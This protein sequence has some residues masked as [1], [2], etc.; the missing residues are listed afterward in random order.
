M[1][2]NI[3]DLPFGAQL[4][5]RTEKTLGA[6]LDRILTDSGLS[7]AEYVAM[8][9]CSELIGSQ[10]AEVEAQ[11]AAVFRRGDDHASALLDRLASAEVIDCDALRPLQLTATGLALR[12]RIA[13]E[14]DMI[15]ER[16]WG[17]LPAGDL[18]VA[19]RVLSTVLR[20]AA[21]EKA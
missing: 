18:A 9:I 1:P 20:R 5:G 8:R 16:L 3:P 7:E 6:L 17:D 21:L 12:D 10:R 14:T 19:A 15:T 11:L 2:N 4:I 13:R